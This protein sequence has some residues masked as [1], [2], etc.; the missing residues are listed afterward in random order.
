[1]GEEPEAGFP[2]K[3][4]RPPVD[5]EIRMLGYVKRSNKPIYEMLERE[6]E[7]RGMRPSKLLE[8]AISHYLSERRLVQSQMS[9]AELYEA[10]TFL[11]ELQR[12]A[13][14]NLMDTWRLYFSEEHIGLVEV[15]KTLYPEERATFEE[16]GLILERKE[17]PPEEYRKVR[18]K[19][20][21]ALEPFLDW[22][23]SLLQK[24]MVDMISKTMPNAPLPELQEAKIPVTLTVEK[25]E[26]P[27]PNP[28]VIKIPEKKR[29]KEKPE[30][31]QVQTEGQS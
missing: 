28:V 6:A 14:R 15:M 25:P 29:R 20:F 7:A 9:V 26:E 31:K 23:M 19:L 12:I 13:I 2:P 10:L 27:E 1:M 5:E 11:N 8:E 22:A 30:E 24:A 17:K 3:K 4:R 18:E 16:R 21:N